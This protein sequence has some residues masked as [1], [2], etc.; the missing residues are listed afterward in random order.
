MVRIIIILLLLLPKTYMHCLGQNKINSQWKCTSHYPVK[1]MK[2]NIQG[3]V[4]IKV[5]FKK[6]CIPKVFS[7]NKSL[8]YG[9]DESALYKIK[10]MAETGR[11][12]LPLECKEGYSKI[13]PI[14][15]AL[16]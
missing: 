6:D 14:K 4:E 7:I 3:I 9:C 10:C 12:E 16:E 8:G 1:A 15:F 11:L 13:Y 2:N 5:T